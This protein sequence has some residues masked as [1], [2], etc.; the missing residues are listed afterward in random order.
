MEFENR[1]GTGVE[2]NTANANSP[3]RPEDLSSP[4]HDGDTLANPRA[5]EEPG[6]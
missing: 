4:K 6:A 1:D 3:E 2:T 5:A